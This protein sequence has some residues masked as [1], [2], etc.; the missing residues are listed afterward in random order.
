[1]G[2]MLFDSNRAR[3]IL[4]EANIDIVIVDRPENFSY[5]SGITR[6][7]E[8]RIVREYINYA[9][10]TSDSQVS[11]IIGW[12]ELESAEEETWVTD[13]FPFRPFADESVGTDADQQR[14]SSAETT[15]AR[16]ISEL[17]LDSSRIGFDEKFT[18]I[19][20]HE[21]IRALLP[22]AHF[23]PATH[24]L[25]Q[26][27]QV[28]TEVEIERLTEAG[29][30]VD[31]AY[32][33]MWSGL[34]NGVT[35]QELAKLAHETFVRE[36]APRISFMHCGAGVR[37]SFECLPPSEN[38]IVPGELIRWD[39]GVCWRGYHSDIGR[40]FVIGKPLTEHTEIYG[41]IHDAYQKTIESMKP[42]IAGCEVYKIFQQGMGS[43]FDITPLV[44]VGHGLG[45]ELHEPPYLGATMTEPLEPGMVFAVEIVFVFS[46]REGYHVEDPILITE[47]GNRRLIDLPNEQLNVLG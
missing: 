4:K 46:G 6:P 17:G 32:R 15:V 14:G 20:V 34:E 39:M 11:L 26:L 29:R 35:E 45:V 33:A 40:T 43:L 3:K 1:M 38:H 36:G 37:S 9:L 8:N 47:D 7:L 31:E 28:K 27:R 42:G 23:V 41:R 25:E 10:L 13:I 18:P 16:R 30:I 12:F 5:I 21:T 19:S 2:E 44:W 24:I 22:K